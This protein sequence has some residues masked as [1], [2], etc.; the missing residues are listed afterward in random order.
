MIDAA[1][2]VGLPTTAHVRAMVGR[3]F[4]L[5]NSSASWSGQI[6]SSLPDFVVFGAKSDMIKNSRLS[7]L[8]RLPTLENHSPLLSFLHALCLPREIRLWRLFHWGSMPFQIRNSQSEIRNLLLLSAVF[9]HAL[10]LFKS[11]I[12]NSKLS[13]GLPPFGRVPSFAIISLCPMLP[14]LWMSLSFPLTKT[15]FDVIFTT[16]VITN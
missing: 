4:T 12:R 1:E 13:F 3:R 7:K 14:F 16:N 5:D 9:P 2:Q 11:A 8:K 15:P 10:C 6:I